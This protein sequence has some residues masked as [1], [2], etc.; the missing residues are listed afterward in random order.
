M[1]QPVQH[2]C[3]CLVMQW[4]CAISVIVAIMPKGGASVTTKI[5]CTDRK[6]PDFLPTCYFSIGSIWVTQNGFQ[7]A[8][9]SIQSRDW[10]LSDS[11][12]ITG[13]PCWNI[14]NY[15]SWRFSSLLNISF[16]SLIDVLRQGMATLQNTKCHIALWHDPPHDPVLKWWTQSWWNKLI[17]PKF[18]CTRPWDFCHRFRV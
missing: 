8:S 5:R 7:N 14:R 9:F 15:G 11:A 1:L 17:T 12:T 2:T 4:L 6:N 3:L 18:H 10:A 13:F 16:M